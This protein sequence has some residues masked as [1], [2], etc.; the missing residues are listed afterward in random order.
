MRPMYENDEN[1]ADEEATAKQ[2]S[3]KWGCEYHKL[4]ISYRIDYAL[5]RHGIVMAFAEVKSRKNH[6]PDRY[7]DYL[8]SL[9]KYNAL[10][11]ISRN[12]GTKSLLVIKWKDRVTFTTVPCEGIR[13]KMGGR[14]DRGDDA[15]IEPMVY[16]PMS[17]FTPV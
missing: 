13:V 8:L 2:V 5:I 16:I 17:N 10:C 15:D 3:E 7:D 14:D 1:R 12:V 4:P 6:T 9:A 11:E